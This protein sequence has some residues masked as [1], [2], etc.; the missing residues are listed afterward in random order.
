MGEGTQLSL[1]LLTT[2]SWSALPSAF[3]VPRNGT[4]V[5]TPGRGSRNRQIASLPRVSQSPTVPPPGPLC[6]GQLLSGQTLSHHQH[7]ALPA[8]CWEQHA[9]PAPSLLRTLQ[10]LPL[11]C[12]I[13]CNLLPR[14]PGVLAL[15][16]APPRLSTF[17]A[18]AGH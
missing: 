10:R 8:P 13:T 2:P 9:C 5:S 17:S 18:L 7:L 14:E 16:G 4:L 12:Q 6:P 3:P 15:K 1:T 11:V